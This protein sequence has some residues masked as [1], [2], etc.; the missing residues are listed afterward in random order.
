[1]IVVHNRDRPEIYEN[2]LIECTITGLWSM[3]ESGYKSY[4]LIKLLLDL[5]TEFDE[6]E[7]LKKNKKKTQGMYDHT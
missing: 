5:Y 4:K 7:R 1:M 2:L 6:C 3:L